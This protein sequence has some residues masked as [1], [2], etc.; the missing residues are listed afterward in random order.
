MELHFYFADN[1]EGLKKYGSEIIKAV[2]GTTFSHFAIGID[3]GGTERIFESV[4][5]KSRTILKTEW[6]KEY[7]IIKDFK[8]IVPEFFEHDLL[9]F[10]FSQMGKW[11]AVEQVVFIAFSIWFKFKMFMK[12]PFNGSKRLICTELGFILVKHF[13]DDYPMYQDSIDL[14]D[15]YAIANTLPKHVEEWG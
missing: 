4:F 12:K 8:Y 1:K 9:K 7:I 15:M 6:L 13:C 14:N 10:L 2:E 11:Y 5:T 3:Y